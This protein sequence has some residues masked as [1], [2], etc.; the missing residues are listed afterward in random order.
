MYP[1]VVVM[2]LGVLPVGSI[3]AELAIYHSSGDLIALAGKWFT[4][5]AIGARLLTAGLM[6]TLNPGYTRGNIFEV[7]DENANDIVRELGFANLALG[8]LGALSILTPAWTP[9]AALAGGLYYGLAGFRHA[10]SRSP[11]SQ[12]KFAMI[13]DLAVAAVFALYLC[14]F[15]LIQHGA[16]PVP[17]PTATGTAI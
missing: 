9:G 17:A 3:V 14:A 6:Q 13:S 12:R 15:Y 2:L 7:A 11:N 10:M 4:F 8:I 5:W 1:V 16:P